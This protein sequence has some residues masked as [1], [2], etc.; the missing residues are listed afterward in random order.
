MEKEGTEIWISNPDMRRW[1]Y[2]MNDSLK[3]EKRA[4]IKETEEWEEGSTLTTIQL[5]DMD[6]NG[7][8]RSTNDGRVRSERRRS[9]RSSSE[10]DSLPGSRSFRFTS[11]NFKN[12]LPLKSEKEL[13]LLITVKDKFAVLLRL[14]PPFCLSSDPF[15]YEKNVHSTLKK[16]RR[17]SWHSLS[18][19]TAI[20]GIPD[21]S[22]TPSWWDVRAILVA[23]NIFLNPQHMMFELLWSFLKVFSEIHRIGDRCWSLLSSPDGR[24]S[25]ISCPWFLFCSHRACCHG[26]T[27]SVRVC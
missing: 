15:L 25:G 19:L 12:G 9:N 26:L 16:H 23:S 18:V 24:G 8:N 6:Q 14:C 21:T 7:R 22:R 20:T 11:R 1:Y 2:Y 17:H 5:Q 10:I 3:P 4:I 13:T 27:S